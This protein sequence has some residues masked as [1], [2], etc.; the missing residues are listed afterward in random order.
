MYISYMW[1][2]ED[3]ER[4]GYDTISLYAIV[5]TN[6]VTYILLFIMCVPTKEAMWLHVID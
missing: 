2:K 5:I 6:S 1:M 4:G 3:F